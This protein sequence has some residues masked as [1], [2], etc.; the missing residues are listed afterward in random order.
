MGPERFVMIHLLL[1]Q[2]DPVGTAESE[3]RFAWRGS[4]ED[5]DGQGP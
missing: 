2:M 5:R 3:S 1:Q 4:R